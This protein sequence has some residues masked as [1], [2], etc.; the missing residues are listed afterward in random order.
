MELDTNPGR[1]D[2]SVV[3]EVRW[4]YEMLRSEAHNILTYVAEAQ[5]ETT[6]ASSV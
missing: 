2:A 4:L 1:D 5:G 6:S 3:Q